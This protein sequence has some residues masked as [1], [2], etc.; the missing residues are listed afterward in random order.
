MVV[1]PKSIKSNA[2]N[3]VDVARAAGKALAKDPTKNGD[4]ARKERH[5]YRNALQVDAFDDG[6]KKGV[7]EITSARE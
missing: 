3:K 1:L 6:F 7:K 4:D 2:C 5:K